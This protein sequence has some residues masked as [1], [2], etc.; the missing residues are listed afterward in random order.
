MKKA[1]SQ[2]DPQFDFS[3]GKKYVP[4]DLEFI[5]LDNVCDQEVYLHTHDRYVL[6][7]GANVP[8]TLQDKLRLDGAKTKFVYILCENEQQLRRFY[9]KNLTTIIEN[10]KV[11]TQKKADVLYRCAIG[12]AQDVFERPDHAETM[13][14]SKGV[15]D[16]TIRLL[17]KDSNAF[18]NMINLSGHDYYTYTH[19]V[20]VLTFTLSLL[21]SL[22]FKDQKFLKDAGMGALL[23]DVGKSK[24][25]VE[26][27]NKPS[28]LTEDEWGVMKMHPAFGGEIVAKAKL[29][30]R[31]V[32][33]IIQHHER[34]NGKGYPHGLTGEN[35]PIASQVVS[36]ADAYDAMTSD[37]VYQKAR[38]PFEAMR[39][40]SQEMKEHYAPGMVETFIKMLNLKK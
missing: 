13:Q 19:S 2:V 15:V 26:I 10:D 29:P 18:A 12:I 33:V 6:Y 37:R 20:N 9:E 22:G 1:I 21:S 11:P 27:L 5:E 28:K 14:R 4:I 25:P 16:C 30:D 36:L 24:V 31:G 17:F 8:F 40:I 34:I 39:I 7:R 35:I 3:G 32:D 23:H 38:S